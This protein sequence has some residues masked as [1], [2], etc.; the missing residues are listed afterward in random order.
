LVKY[1]YLSFLLLQVHIGEDVVR[2]RALR[3]LHTKLTTAGQEILNKEA[4]AQ[5]VAEVKK[6]FASVSIVRSLLKMIQGT[7]VP[8]CAYGS[9][10]TLMSGLCF[11]SSNQRFQNCSS[12]FSTAKNINIKLTFNCL[13]WTEIS[14]LNHPILYFCEI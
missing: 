12:N 5:I 11:L 4:Q 14:F 2:E 3:L 8:N 6:V 9:K 1:F 7:K 13:L 10:L